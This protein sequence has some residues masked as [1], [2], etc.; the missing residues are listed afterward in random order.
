[1]IAVTGANGQLGKLVIQHLLKLENVH[2]LV[3]IV[4]NKSQSEY[5]GTKNVLLREA[6]Y[7][8]PDTLVSALEGVITLL[9][10]SS[11]AVGARVKQHQNVVDAAVSAGVKHIVYTSIRNADTTPMLMAE[12]HKATEAYIQASG[13]KHTFL[14]N[15]W[16]S[17]NYLQQL[18]FYLETGLM[19]SVSQTGRYSTAPRDDYAEAAARIIT[20]PILL[21]QPIYE[22]AGDDSFT[23][24]ELATRIVRASG[25]PLKHV[26]V[27]QESMLEALLDAQL[28]DVF[29]RALVDSE[30]QSEHG[31]LEDNSKMLSQILQRPTVPIE[32]LL[33]TVLKAN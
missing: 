21:K 19:T 22:L 28:P 31:W 16:Y 33:E 26:T 3:G 5:L 13:L 6:D 30:V 14:R 17:E 8:A 24:P 25:K 10:I 12:E 1:M 11:N 2:G 32:R 27:T 9:L 18:P 23:L 4:R 7:E 20:S 29:A 15:G